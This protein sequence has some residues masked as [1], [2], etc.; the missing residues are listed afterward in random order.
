MKEDS[1]CLVPANL[2]APVVEA[3]GSDVLRLTLREPLQPNGDIILYN[4]FL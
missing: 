2:T 3:V 1:T 4:V